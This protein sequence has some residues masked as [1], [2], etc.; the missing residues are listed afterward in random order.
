MFPNASKKAGRV[1]PMEEKG[2]ESWACCHPM[3]SKCHLSILTVL[4]L[5]P[6][7]SKYARIVAN[8]A[9]SPWAPL[10]R[11]EEKDQSFGFLAS[12]Y[13]FNIYWALDT[14]SAAH[15]N[16]HI[17]RHWGKLIWDLC[18]SWK[19]SNNQNSFPSGTDTHPLL[20]KDGP[21]SSGQCIDKTFFYYGKFQILPKQ[22]ENIRNHHVP[23]T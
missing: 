9:Y 10:Q 5:S 17:P 8:P 22:G 14:C 3:V 16:S 21:F 12:I 2:P 6:F 18:M 20:P 11:Q 23:I 1:Y 15:K 19:V 13:S 4:C 7:W